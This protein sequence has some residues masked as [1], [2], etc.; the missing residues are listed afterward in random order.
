MEI[1]GGNEGNAAAIAIVMV[2]VGDLAYHLLCL[3]PRHVGV[4]GWVCP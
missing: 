1:A 2:A 4:D 3:R